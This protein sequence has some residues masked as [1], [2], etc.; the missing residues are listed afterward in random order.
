MKKSRAIISILVAFILLFCAVGCAE[1]DDFDGFE[2]VGVVVVENINGTKYDSKVD[3]YETTQ[4][5]WSKFKKLDIN[6]EAD[7]SVGSSYLY[8]CFYDKSETTLGVFTIY[9]NGCCCL[10]EDFNTLYT[11]TDGRSAYLELCDIYTETENNESS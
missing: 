10:G 11:V 1:T 8:L 6:E 9:D 3:D 7:G 2:P 4:K 5:L